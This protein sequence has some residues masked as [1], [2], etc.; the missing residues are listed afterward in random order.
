MKGGVYMLEEEKEARLEEMTVFLQRRNLLK[1]REMLLQNLTA[2]S[3]DKEF[4]TDCYHLVL[5][6]PLIFQKHNGEILDYTVTHWEEERYPAL[7]ADLKKNFSRKRY[8]LAMNVACYF[9]ELK[10]QQEEVEEQEELEV[11]LKEKKKRKPKKPKRILPREQK[12]LLTGIT[13]TS[14][15][16]IGMVV[17]LILNQE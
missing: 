3:E 1:V 13:T 2:Y 6:D 5:G 15:L 4:L 8:H 16:L 11:E 9:E 14:L 17:Q 7:L 12:Y 10:Q